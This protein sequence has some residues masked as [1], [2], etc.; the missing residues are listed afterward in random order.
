MLLSELFSLI[1]FY[2]VLLIS[3]GG[4]FLV[5]LQSNAAKF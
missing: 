2:S 4:W 5:F 3:W 1:A